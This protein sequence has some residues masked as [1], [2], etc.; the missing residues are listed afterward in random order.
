MQESVTMRAGGVELLD[1]IEPLW[2][3]LRAHHAELT[4]TWRESLL[5]A[6]FPDRRGKLITK[7]SCGLRVFL[8]IADGRI[9]G[10]CICT[11]A[12][13]NQGEID[14]IFVDDVHRRHGVGKTLMIHAMDW[15]NTL[16][17]APIVV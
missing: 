12:S 17:A 15:L 3:Q 5:D 6:G 7:G 1:E 13:N 8:A 9:I 16:R 4:D 2:R 11:I 14:S 10:Y